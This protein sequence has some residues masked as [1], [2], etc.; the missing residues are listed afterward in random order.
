MV[1]R[2]TFQFRPQRPAPVLQWACPRPPRPASQAGRGQPWPSVTA[3]LFVAWALGAG[4]DNPC[5]CAGNIR[6][7]LAGRIWTPPGLPSSQLTSARKNDCTRTFGQ[8]VRD[9]LGVTDE[10]CGSAPIAYTHSKCLVRRKLRQP[11]F[12]LSCH[13]LAVCLSNPRSGSPVRE[14]VVDSCYAVAYPASRPCASSAQTV[15]AALF[16]IAT[17]QC[18]CFGASSA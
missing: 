2:V 8:S 18:S 4:T 6:D 15:R 1:G 13:Q 12:G 7:G 11:R 16:A 17:L 9:E 3:G 14:D 10:Y 5:W